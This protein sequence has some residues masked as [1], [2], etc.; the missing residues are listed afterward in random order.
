MSVAFRRS[1]SGGPE[2]KTVIC[3]IFRS[4]QLLDL[5]RE[6]R[7]LFDVT[8]DLGEKRP[9]NSPR[10]APSERESLQGVG[11]LIYYH[12]QRP[13]LCSPAAMSTSDEAA[14]VDAHKPPTHT[15]PGTTLRWR[16]WGRFVTGAFFGCSSLRTPSAARPCARRLKYSC[17]KA[18]LL[19][20]AFDDAAADPSLER[21]IS[22]LSWQCLA[23]FCELY[24]CI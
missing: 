23:V 14:S 20:V 13:S 4:A 21:F 8:D 16:I 7:R 22:P 5:A 17:C 24:Q 3:Y 9:R 18:E 15:L 19:D 6:I 1:C 10:S 11:S 12:C 2:L